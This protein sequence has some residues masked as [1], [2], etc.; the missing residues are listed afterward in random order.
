MT[1]TI[2][3]RIIVGVVLLLVV[4]PLWVEAQQARRVY[5]VGYLGNISSPVKAPP[6]QRFVGVFRDAGLVEGQHIVFERRFAEGE[7]DR[8]PAL[9]AE[10][11][12]L[13]LD[14]V[15]TA[16]VPA[17]TAARQSMPTMAIVAVMADLVGNG[18]AA[19]VARPGGN[20]TGFSYMSPEVS[21]KRLEVLREVVPGVFRVGVLWNPGNVHEPKVMEAV[22]AAAHQL[23][24]QLQPVEVRRVAEY[25][26]AFDTLRSQRAE[27]LI[28]FE[29]VL[30][31]THRQR[32]TDLALARRLPTIFELP[33]FVAAGGLMAYG[34]TPDEWYGVLA[35]QAIK[36]LRGAR[37]AEIPVQQPT[38]FELTLNLKTARTLG[39]TVPPPLLLRADRV[40]E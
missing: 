5:R 40:I 4:V 13:P 29:N 18:F 34:P 39:L 38:R 15:V 6:W 28:V 17:A 10:L 30:N 1:A 35:S 27:A 3:R 12:A 36:I 25:E 16:G 21:A 31:N 2:S 8:Y 23:R 9:A 11:A 19:T 22:A 33:L 37:P 24:I 20:V 32:I 14:V 26:A 7:V